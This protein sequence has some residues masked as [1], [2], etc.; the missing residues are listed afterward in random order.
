MGPS[1][2]SAANEKL[3]VETL[4]LQTWT[5]S[6]VSEAGTS[7]HTDQDSA[8]PAAGLQTFRGVSDH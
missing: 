7:E 2:C 4:Q 8:G 5:T 6:A 1:D 3:N